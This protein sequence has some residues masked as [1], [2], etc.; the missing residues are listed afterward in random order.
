MFFQC[1]QLNNDQWPALTPYAAALNRKRLD[2]A[3]IVQVPREQAPV[4]SNII[5]F[6]LRGFTQMVTNRHS[7]AMSSS[8]LCS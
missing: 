5:V 8:V 2:E 6:E 4:A 1:A 7:F 3:R